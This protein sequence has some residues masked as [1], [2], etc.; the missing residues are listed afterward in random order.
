M[1]SD[2]TLALSLSFYYAFVNDLGLV[3]G[4]NEEPVAALLGRLLIKLATKHPDI[5]AKLTWKERFSL[6]PPHGN[7]I[8]IYVGKE[9]IDQLKSIGGVEE[10]SVSLFASALLKEF[11]SMD[12]QT[13]KTLLG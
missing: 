13:K 6:R 7:R 4:E 9:V 12:I 5:L 1:T 11:K 10:K 8:N 2:T 3:G